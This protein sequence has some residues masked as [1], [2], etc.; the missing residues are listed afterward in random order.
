MFVISLFAV[1]GFL[2]GLTYV[3]IKRKIKPGRILA[4][5]FLGLLSVGAWKIFRDIY[6]HRKKFY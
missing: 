1:M 4:A 2:V 6:K 3:M 5:T